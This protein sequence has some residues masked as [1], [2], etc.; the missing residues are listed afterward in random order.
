MG[1]LFKNSD[2]KKLTKE[3]FILL[4]QLADA[5]GTTT[6]EEADEEARAEV[7]ERCKFLKE[8]AIKTAEYQKNLHASFV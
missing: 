7:A 3:Q 4:G 5:A 8:E 6:I 1:L 2:Y